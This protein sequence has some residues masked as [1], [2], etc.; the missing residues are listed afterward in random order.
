MICHD[1]VEFILVKLAF[2][3]LGLVNS[4]PEELWVEAHNTVQEAVKK[5]FPK[6]R[7]ARRSSGYLRRLYK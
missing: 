4:V 6:K 1:Q 7:K 2:K 5:T 3:G